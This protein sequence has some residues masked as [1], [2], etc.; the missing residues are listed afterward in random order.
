M[1]IGLICPYNIGLGGGVQECVKATYADLKNR[2][3]DVRIITPMSKEVRDHPPQD[4]ILLGTG[5]DIRSPFATTAQVSATFNTDEIA[6]V[7]DVEKF[8]IL[9]FHE[10]WVPMLSRQL[11][12]KSRSINVATFHARMPDGMMTK[13]IERVITPY[14][15]SI[16]KSFDV[17]TAVSDPAAQYVRSLTD[18]PVQ[19]IPNGID[20]QK[21]KPQSVAKSSKTRNILFIGRLE[22]RK[23]LKYL[24]DAFARL[25]DGSCELRIAGNGP[26]RQKLEDYTKKLSLNNVRFLGFVSDEEKLKLLAE[27][28]VFCSP[29]IYGESFG[30]VLLEAMA[31]GVPVV[32]ANNPGYATVMQGRGFISLVDPKDTEQFAKRLALMLYDK[33]FADLWRA[34][35]ADYVRQFAYKNIVDQ[36]ESLYERLMK[37]A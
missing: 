7:L 4:T 9:H 2:G 11:L 3:H 32:A 33:E 10:P 1:K 37:D 17:L 5:T 24:L 31:A 25:A 23:G 29:A 12:A 26:D 14:T 28:D 34:W 13:T 35:A 21:Y 8:D 36:Y 16:L 19:I 27:A 22:R 6:E 20:L 18:D 30:I 15:K